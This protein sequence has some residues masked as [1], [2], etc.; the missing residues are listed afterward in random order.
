[1][2]LNAVPVQSLSHVIY[3]E[4]PD[5][6]RLTTRLT[7]RRFQDHNHKTHASVI[8]FLRSRILQV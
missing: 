6:D 8:Q 2:K 3:A 4:Y 1:M 5:V 7:F